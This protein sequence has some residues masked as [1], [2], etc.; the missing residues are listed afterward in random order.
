MVKLKY[1]GKEIEVSATPIILM[2]E[3]TF[4]QHVFTFI[5]NGEEYKGYVSKGGKLVVNKP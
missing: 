1:D 5:V 2:V 4:S 3:K